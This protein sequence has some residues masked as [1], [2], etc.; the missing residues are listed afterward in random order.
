MIRSNTFV[1]R[2]RSSG[3][4]NRITLSVHAPHFRNTVFGRRTSSFT[5]IV[6]TSLHN[7]QRFFVGRFS[8]FFS[9]FFERTEIAA[10]DL[11][12][13]ATQHRPEILQGLEQS[14]F[15]PGYRIVFYGSS[16]NNLK[17]IVY[18]K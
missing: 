12:L 13:A 18:K 15:L 11:C 10:A 9:S 16:I 7:Q 8:F 4:R 2:R 1:V 6:F 17:I 3:A 5:T 14:N